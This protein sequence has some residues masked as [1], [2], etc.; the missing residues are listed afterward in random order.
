MKNL[1]L[2]NVMRAENKKTTIP[3][4]AFFSMTQDRRRCHIGAF[5]SGL[6]TGSREENA[7]GPP[8]PKK[9]KRPVQDGA[10]STCNVRAEALT[11]M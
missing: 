9:K 5:S 4:G 10:L 11:A 2:M 1:R 8:L 6:D 7:I 3:H